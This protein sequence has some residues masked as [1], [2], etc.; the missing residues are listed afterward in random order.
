M[1]VAEEKDRLV[2][3]EAEAKWRARQAEKALAESVASA[4]AAQKVHSLL[5]MYPIIVF[6]MVTV[7]CA[8]SLL[9]F[10]ACDGRLTT[11]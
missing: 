5:R 8:L 4:E 3:A 6:G 9:H 10:T 11:E 1:A 7:F 2:P